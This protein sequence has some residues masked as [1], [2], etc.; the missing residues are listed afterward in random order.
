MTGTNSLN[1]RRARTFGIVVIA[2]IGLSACYGHR[3]HGGGHGHSGYSGDYRA[4]PPHGHSRV[5]GYRDGRGH[6][7][8]GDRHRR[9]DRPSRRD[10]G[11][12]GR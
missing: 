10:D 9:E 6:R 3:S 12:R 5:Y 11:R 8:D 2:A 7:A 1:W 4:A